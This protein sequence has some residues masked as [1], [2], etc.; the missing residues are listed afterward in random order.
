MDNVIIKICNKELKTRFGSQRDLFSMIIP[1]GFP[2]AVFIPQ[3]HQSMSLSG[4]EN[5]LLRFMLFLIIPIMITT[6]IGTSTFINEIRWKTIKSLLV[7]P[8]SE[9]DKLIQSFSNSYVSILYDVTAGREIVIIS[10]KTNILT[11]FFSIFCHP[12]NSNFT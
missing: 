1:I 2:I 11:I 10:V 12:L 5:E 4:S 6:L 8:I 3:I 7:A 9:S